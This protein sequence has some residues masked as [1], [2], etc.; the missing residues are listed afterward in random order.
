[1]S[2][3]LKHTPGP[4]TFDPDSQKIET[5][6][7]QPLGRVFDAFDREYESNKG[8]GSDECEEAEAQMLGNGVLWAGSPGLLAACQAT[9]ECLPALYI[10]GTKSDQKRQLTIRILNDAIAAATTAPGGGT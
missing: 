7:G 8:F 3:E 1:M 2:N 6:D 9:V 4:L 10:P 5:E